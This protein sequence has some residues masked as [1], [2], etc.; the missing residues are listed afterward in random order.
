MFGLLALTLVACKEQMSND[1][2]V[3]NK[4][5][6]VYADSVKEG[7]WVARVLS[8]THIITNYAPTD[9]TLL[10]DDGIVRFRLA[11]NGHDNEL[12]KHTYH[13]AVMG[14]DTTITA[15]EVNE[16]PKVKGNIEATKW[17]LKVDLRKM[18][19]KLG[20]DGFFATPTGDTIYKEEY[21]GVWLAGNI[22]RCR[23]TFSTL[24]RNPI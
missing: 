5:F 17:H 16:C 6:T 20:A 19:E 23:G 2:V 11:F 18:E 21:K 4:Y 13:Y 1:V 24:S 7:D 3:Q 10:T 14:S 12:P 9:T 22:H 15:F 8:P